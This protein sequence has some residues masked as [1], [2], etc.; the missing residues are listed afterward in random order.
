[1]N[2]QLNTFE[3]FNNYIIQPTA[4]KLFVLYKKIATIVALAFE[5]LRSWFT[6]CFPFRK[7]NFNSKAN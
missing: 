5:A 7:K 3:D 2:I 1:M 6:S 4:T